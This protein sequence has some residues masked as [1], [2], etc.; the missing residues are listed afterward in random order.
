MNRN[1]KFWLC[2]LAFAVSISACT[3]LST[4][5]VDSKVE[6]ASGS[7]ATIDPAEGLISA[8]KDLGA[9][10]DQANIYALFEH[11]TDEMIPPTRGVDW[12]DNG[13][14]R[15]LYTHTWDPT[16]SYVLGAWNQLNQRAFKSNQILAS[17]PSAAQAAEAKFL[18]AFHMW[19]V[20]DLFGQVPFREFNEG[21]D[22]NPKVLSRSEAFDFIV[23]DLEE[24]LPGL[25]NT[26]PTASNSKATKAAA[27]AL[28]ARLYL[29][30][31][32][33]KSEI[34][35]GPYTFDAADMNKVIKYADDV[36]AAGYALEDDYFKNFS[37][38]A[39]TE[40][41]FTTAEGTPQNRWFMTLHYNQ[42]PSG[43]N[44]FTTLADFYGK[45]EAGD[46]RKGT[47]ATGNG[48]AFSGIG[49]GFLIGDQI[50]D[51]GTPLI[52]TRTQK[53]LSFTPDVPLSGAATD[54]GI[55]VIKYHPSDNGQYI[56]LRYADVY[57]MKAE[58]IMRGGT[59]NTTA[60][61]M[62]NALRATRNASALTSINEAT[63][64]DERG[65]E[66]YW[67][68]I[69]RVDQIRFGTFNNTWSEKTN[70]EPFRVLFPI[71]QQALDS[72]PNL[73]PNPGY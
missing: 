45:F 55:R 1:R 3:D 25:D 37:K 46:E 35:E 56:L 47:P 24:A 66:L 68:G 27:N 43:W 65:R 28:L 26:G 11:T 71:P 40:V 5:E 58:A 57:L 32:V 39:A 18:R 70:T 38:N 73:K 52:D 16:H 17:N 41:I 30:K 15:S 23:K 53:Q 12:S 59:S 34:P 50:K 42:N 72:N 10:T 67:E 6:A 14:W 63:M 60:L 7:G 44:G 21:V 20:M 48:T 19:H 31:A 2:S 8:Y 22:V 29:N 33:Y 13:V 9:Y 36:A 54:K 49:R 62:V 64:L 51:D 61:A 4:N 69:R